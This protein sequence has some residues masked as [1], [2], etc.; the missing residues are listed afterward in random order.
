MSLLGNNF[1]IKAFSYVGGGCISQTMRLQTTYG[2]LF[3]KYNNS[4]EPEFFSREAECLRELKKNSAGKLVIPEVIAYGNVGEMP[5]FILIEFLEAGNTKGQDAKLGAGLAG[6]HQTKTDNQFGFTH[7]NYCGSTPQKNNWTDNWIDFFTNNRL[8]YLI[9]L[10]EAR[11]SLPGRSA[12]DKL[13]TK[14]PDLLV[15]SSFPSLIHGDLWSGNYLYTINGPALIDPASYYADREMELSIMKMFGGFSAVT[16]DSYNEAFPLEY[17][18]KNRVDI[19][20]IYHYLN[21][22]YLFGGS[23]GHQALRIAQRFV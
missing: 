22:F 18:W 12:Y 4:V 20:Q 17:G 13:I 19:Y 3:L 2:N 11:Q 1:D 15:T 16:W 9:S 8:L 10:I 5:G 14:L 23:Y 21:H 7:D 6:L